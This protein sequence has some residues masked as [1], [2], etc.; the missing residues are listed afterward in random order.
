MPAV[1]HSV[2]S[3]R[4][5]AVAG[6]RRSVRDAIMDVAVELFHDQGYDTVSIEDIA[7]AVGLSARTFY[8]YF[9]SKSEVMVAQM[10]RNASFMPAAVL[11]RPDTESP[12]EG[13]FRAV[14]SYD[15]TVDRGYW[16]NLQIYRNRAS[17][18]NEWSAAVQSQLRTILAEAIER[19]WPEQTDPHVLAGVVMGVLASVAERT[20]DASVDR[21]PKILQACEEL[22]TAIQ[23]QSAPQRPI[24]R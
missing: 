8:R 13:V 17:G 14:A 19:R 4:D 10:V 18:V 1:E 9:S 21:R 5:I 20:P 11:A 15:D 2:L 3:L 16:R 12:L 6:R 7:H 23:I 24:T 22:R